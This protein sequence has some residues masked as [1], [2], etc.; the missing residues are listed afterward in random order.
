V[1]FKQYHYH[2]WE[3]SPPLLIQQHLTDFLNQSGYAQS[4]ID[5]RKGAY[6]YVLESRIER[7]DRLISD[8]DATAHIAI[9]FWLMDRQDPERVLLHQQYEESVPA[10]T[11]TIEATVMAFSAGIDRISRRVL[12]DLGKVNP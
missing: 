3:D 4:V 5:Q 10:E 7:F 8:T 2:H 12:D 6:Q 11:M 9:E 1:R